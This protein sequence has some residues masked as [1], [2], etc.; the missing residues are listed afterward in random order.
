VKREF[1]EFVS[2]LGNV[3]VRLSCGSIVAGPGLLGL[4]T[5]RLARRKPNVM[6]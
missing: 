3:Y 4:A 1:P 2:H 5:E 6:P